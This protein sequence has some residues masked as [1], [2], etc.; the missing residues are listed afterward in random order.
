[1]KRILFV[2]RDGT[3]I[4][5]PEDCQ[6]DELSKLKLKEEVI[7]CLKRLIDHGYLLVMV[8]N[9]DGLGTESFPKEDFTRCQN[10]LLS[11]LR[12]QGVVFY[13]VLICPHRAEDDCKCRKPDLGLVVPYLKDPEVDWNHSYVIGDRESDLKLAQNMNISGFLIQSPETPVHLKT[14][15]WKEITELILSKPRRGIA[16]RE[17]Q[18]TSIEVTVALDEPAPPQISTGLAFFDHMLEQL[19]HHSGWFLKIKAQGD[20]EVDHHH[21][22]E[23]TA[24]CLGRALSQALSH[25]A[26][27]GRYGFALPMDESCCEVLVDL[28][29]RPY[30][31]FKGENYQ[32]SVANIDVDMFQ[33]FFRSLALE[34]PCN[35]HIKVTGKNTHHMVESMFKA[36]AR[37]LKGAAKIEGDSQMIAS[38]KGIL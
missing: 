9:Q 21:T 35:L 25:R 17:S 29:R 16:K 11:L 20:L 31:V 24:L 6:V 10:M 12:S 19:G 34:L 30:F 7:L 32:G 13:D 18:E 14:H 33:H 5:E 22:I 3:I 37:A 4:E 2:D 23:D 27:I 26:C 1:M 28:A 36:V 38:T 8:T 15:S